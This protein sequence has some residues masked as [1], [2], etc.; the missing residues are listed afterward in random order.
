MFGQGWI[1]KADGHGQK[2]PK[3][4]HSPHSGPQWRLAAAAERASP[5]WCL[6]KE[7]T[8]IQRPTLEKTQCCAFERLPVLWKGRR[9]LV[10][11][12][13]EVINYAC[14]ISSCSVSSCSAALPQSPPPPPPPPPT[15]GPPP[16]FFLS[17]PSLSLSVSL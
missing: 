7:D 5:H 12:V 14:N 11:G 1:R 3:R 4:L 13:G 17:S 8:H 10:R 15:P 6:G 16:L 2:S 9:G